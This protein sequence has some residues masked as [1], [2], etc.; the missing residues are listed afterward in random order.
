MEGYLAFGNVMGL[1]RWTGGAVDVK[2][3]IG[4]GV[5]AIRGWFSE[6]DYFVRATCCFD[7]IVS[8][9]ASHTRKIEGYQ[10][11]SFVFYQRPR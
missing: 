9:R 6:V 5:V 8:V 11:D 4:A 1:L 10:I 7:I 3:A 2:L